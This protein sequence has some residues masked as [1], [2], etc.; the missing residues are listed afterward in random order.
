MRKWIITVTFPNANFFLFKLNPFH[1]DCKT[2]FVFISYKFSGLFFNFKTEGQLTHTIHFMFY[3]K[4]NQSNTLKCFEDMDQLINIIN[5]K[6]ELRMNG[7]NGLRGKK[8]WNLT[9]PYGVNEKTCFL[10]V[11]KVAHWYTKVAINL[12]EHI[13]YQYQSTCCSHLIID[14]VPCNKLGGGGPG[15]RHNQYWKDDTHC[16]HGDYHPILSCRPGHWMPVGTG[17]W[18]WPSRPCL[19]MICRKTLDLRHLVI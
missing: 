6:N 11:W 18:I 15:G 9:F 17:S 8:C 5:L 13:S 2:I 7:W 14:K 10:K 19:M 12:H 3:I 16:Q 4:N 1:P